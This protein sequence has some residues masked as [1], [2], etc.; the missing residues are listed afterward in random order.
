WSATG[1]K[2]DSATLTT[3]AESGWQTVTLATPVNITTNTTYVASYHTTGTYVATNNFFTADVTSGVLTA[4]SSANAGGNGVY[5]YG[6]TST[7]GIFPTSTFGASNYGADVVFT[8]SGGGGG[9]GNTPPT[10]VADT[11]EAT[12]KGGVANG[13]GGLPAS[14]NVL[15]NDT[16]PNAGD[17]K[18]VSAVSFGAAAGTLG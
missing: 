14:G 4:P 2:R 3:P 10:A 18:T 16:D 9:G 17:T 11:A 1:T 6:G 8:S 13:S 5:S 15:T 7:A 12:E